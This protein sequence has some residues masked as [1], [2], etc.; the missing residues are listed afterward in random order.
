MSEHNHALVTTPD[1]SDRDALIARLVAG[2]DSKHTRRA[3]RNHIAE[4]E[5]FLRRTGQLVSKESVTAFKGHLRDAGKSASAINQRLSAVRFFIRE[6]A[7]AGLLQQVDAERA[8]KVKSVKV[9]G[10]K[11]G[12]R[13]SKGE[14]ADILNAPDTETA[15]G[16]RDRAALAL[17]L[18]AGLRRHEAA[19][20]TVEHIQQDGGRWVITNLIGKGNKARRVPL[21]SWFK[22][23]IDDW[24]QAAGI[25]T[26]LILR[27]CSW[28]K[29][30]FAVSERGL[31]E[32]GI[33]R[34]V[35]RYAR[36]MGKTQLGPHDMRRTF[37]KL[38]RE[39]QAPLEQIQ[40]SL[41]HQSLNTTKLYVG[42]EQDLKTAPSDLIV[43]ELRPRTQTQTASEGR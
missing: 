2:L 1:T 38:A 29:G 33:Y 36:P 19:T 3:Y 6:A 32:Q 4:F 7:D 9:S 43:L 23:L 11:H 20:L 27:Q 37:A 22:S 25:T 14:A 31:S 35:Q 39:G 10:Q 40:L 42:D 28:A 41:G 12:H 21:A 30:K 5:A 17:L 24:C 34:I 26:G 18:G 15:L 13:L 16:L 8:C